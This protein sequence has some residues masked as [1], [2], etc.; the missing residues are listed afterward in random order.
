MLTKISRDAVGKLLRRANKVG[1]SRKMADDSYPHLDHSIGMVSPIN[2]F[3]VA[4]SQ[5]VLCKFFGDFVA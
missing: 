4:Y 1:S 2:F 5:L 3:F